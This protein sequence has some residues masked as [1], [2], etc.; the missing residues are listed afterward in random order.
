MRTDAGLVS[1]V[2][3]GQ[4]REHGLE[5]AR[6]IHEAL[7]PRVIG[8]SIF[9]GERVGETMFALSH[10][11]RDRKTLLE[12]I[13]CVDCALWDLVGKALGKS[14]GALRGG[15]GQRLPII[16][17]GGY[18][19]EGKPLADIGGEMEAYRRAGMAGCKFKVGGLTPEED[20]KRV[21][22]ARRAAGADFVLA[23]DANRGWSAPDAIRFARLIEPLD[24]RW[25]EEPCHWYDDVALMA[26]V[27]RAT[28]NPVTARQSEVTSHPD[29]PPLDPGAD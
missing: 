18:Y 2:C 15:Y 20:A 10:A 8:M 24:I 27:R 1:E 11:S 22:A 13:A 6:R 12:A 19:M 3:T 4:T 26:R 7:A 21:D 9:E 5:I 23:V 17:I 16:S 25:F 14:V 28:R 29:R